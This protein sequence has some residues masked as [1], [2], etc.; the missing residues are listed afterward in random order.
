MRKQFKET[1]SN[2]FKKDKKSVLILGDIGVYS[3]KDLFKTH[4]N[5]TFNVGIIE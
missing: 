5:R 4:P 3:F 1:V 2:I